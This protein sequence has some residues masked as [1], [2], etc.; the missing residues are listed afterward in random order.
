MSIH[1]EAPDGLALPSA[2][3]VMTNLGPL[4]AYWTGLR[5]AR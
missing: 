2:D 3:T 4:Y 1:T 5:K